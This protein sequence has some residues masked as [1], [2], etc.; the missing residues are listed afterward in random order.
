MI[1][2]PILS[3]PPAQPSPAR[4]NAADGSS[5]AALREAARAFEAAFL[6]E[7]LKHSGLGEAPEGFGG[8]AGEAQFASHL[9]AAQARQMADAGGLGLAEH[10]FESMKARQDV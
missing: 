2:S 6:T 8:G 7:M 3:I 4:A 10:I 1:D 9:R 5:D